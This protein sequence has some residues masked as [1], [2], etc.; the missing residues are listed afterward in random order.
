M[1]PPPSFGGSIFGK[2]LPY[3]LMLII[4]AIL[5]ASPVVKLPLYGPMAYSVM[6]LL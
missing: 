2:H 1:K 4:T 3:P 5:H 6:Q